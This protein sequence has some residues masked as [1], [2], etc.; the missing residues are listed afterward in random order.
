MGRRH[1]RG[2]AAVVLALVATALL[3]G[4]RAV[5]EAGESQGEGDPM[6]TAGP[7]VTATQ[8]STQSNEVPEDPALV[9][10]GRQL[11][12]TS[13]VSC[14]G[15][16]GVGS[17]DGPDIRNA[18]QA[19]ADF[20]LRTGRMPMA[21][22]SPQP[23][24]KP[25]AYNDEQ[26]RQLVAYVGSLGEGPAIPHIDVSKGNLQ[27]GSE[28]YLSNCAACHNSSAVG[29]AISD[30]RYA[31]S[32]QQTEAQQVG[33]APRVGPGEM[34]RFGP[35][36]ITDEELN[37]IATYV[38]YLRNPRDPG[39]LNLGYT[40]P[41]SEG[42]VALLFGLGGLILVIRWITRESAVGSVP[43]AHGREGVPVPPAESTEASRVGP[44]VASPETN[45]EVN[46]E[47]G[48]A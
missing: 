13:C 22:P 23:P 40:G 46:P 16:D 1:R 25:P 2:L 26:I 35:E 32:L 17:A 44:T 14:H 30:G 5:A 33:E 19:G 29:G 45:A 34:P 3:L 15:V 47:D 28:L 41:V 24:D 21:A 48:H 7:G 42:F 18:G 38:E 31:P 11:Y 8:S 12:L 6:G 10:A 39:G 37:D 20:M 43:R 27:R 36:V 9:E 4:V